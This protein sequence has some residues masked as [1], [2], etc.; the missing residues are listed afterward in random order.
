MHLQGLCATVTAIQLAPFASMQLY[1]G[2]SARKWLVQQQL[3]G[4]ATAQRF[5]IY[6][7]CV[8]MYLCVL[9]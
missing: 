5:D 9:L 8:C 2:W 1:S 6:V 3:A 4:E 7:N